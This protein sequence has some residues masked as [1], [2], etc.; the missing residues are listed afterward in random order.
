METEA[1]IVGR[2]RKQ[3]HGPAVS[4]G[5]GVYDPGNSTIPRQALSAWK[6]HEKLAAAKRGE[7]PK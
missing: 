7:K 1:S 3:K 2:A 6:R 5:R 4:T